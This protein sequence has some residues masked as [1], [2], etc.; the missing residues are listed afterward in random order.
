MSSRA[1]GLVWERA[2]AKGS[3]LLVLLK[4]ADLADDNGKRF[5][6]SNERLQQFSRMSERSLRYILRKLTRDGEIVIE[7]NV[8]G[9]LPEK[10]RGHVP[11]RFI[12]VRCVY[13]WGIYEHERGAKIAPVVA[14]T[15]GQRLPRH[16]AKSGHA[17][18]QK[19]PLSKRKDLLVDPSVDS[20]AAAAPP[21]RDPA[22]P[23]FASYK[24]LEKLT[25]EVLDVE[26]FETRAELSAAVKTRVSGLQLLYD[27]QVL[28]RAIE[29][30]VIFRGYN[31]AASTRRVQ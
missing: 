18:D 1:V 6:M 13:D 5:W 3:N 4:I 24:L 28:A 2:R 29:S 15:R 14:R 22:G 10:S 9:I 23:D 16:S 26:A 27:P 21:P 19:L 8:K 31:H 11:D 20:K 17:G 25:H 7:R 12:H 30:V